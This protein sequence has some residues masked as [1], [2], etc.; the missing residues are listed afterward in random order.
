[1][2]HIVKDNKP[3]LREKCKP[4][5]MPLSK[6]NKELIDEM[7]QYLLLTQDEDYRK[8]HPNVRE[9][10]GLAAPQVGHNLRMIVIS[11]ATG[12]E[13]N[14]RVQY[15]LVNPRI[16]VNSVKKCY[17]SGGEGC[18][19]VDGEHRGKVYRDFKIVVK[20]FEAGLGKDIEITARG[21]DAIVLQHEID[22]L[23]G[24]LFYDRIDKKDPFKEIPGSVEI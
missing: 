23:D 7:L 6:E 24:I 20:A 18:L 10:V 8:K 17:L 21:Y 2:L 14:P 22:H 3:S 13:K 12:D 16:V 1:M 15:Q 9:G 19:S 4:V 11:Y 5:E